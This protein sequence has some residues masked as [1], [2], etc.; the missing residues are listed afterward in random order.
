MEETFYETSL[1]PS[2]TMP[3]AWVGPRADRLRDHFTNLH[4]TDPS[5]WAF[6]VPFC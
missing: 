3:Q 4:A 5:S 1:D 2:E 6:A